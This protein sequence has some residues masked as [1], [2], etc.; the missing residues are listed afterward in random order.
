VFQCIIFDSP[1][2]NAKLIGI[3]YIIPEEI[4][5][6]LPADEKVLWHSHKHE[7]ASGLLLPLQTS[8]AASAVDAVTSAF[9]RSDQETSSGGLRAMPEALEKMHMQLLYKTYGKIM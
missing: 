5:K 2:K 9:S 6:T 7:V 4:F 1:L 3:E 8:V